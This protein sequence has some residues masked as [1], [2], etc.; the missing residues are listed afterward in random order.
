MPNS[1]RS[2]PKSSA[3][4]GDVR[5]SR[6]TFSLLSESDSEAETP[7]SPP[8]VFQFQPIDPTP[9]GDQLSYEELSI[10]DNYVPI[11]S[12][13][14]TETTEADLWLQ[15]WTN[16]LEVHFSDCYDTSALTEAD[17]GAMMTWLYAQGWDIQIETRDVIQACPD[18]LPPRLWIPDRFSRIG[19]SPV[20]YRDGHCHSHHA[21]VTEQKPKKVKS[22][23]VPRFCRASSGGVPCA[24]A[25]CRYV[26]A[27]TMPRLNQP[28]GFGAGCGASDPTGVKRGQ[29]LYMHPGETWD[30]T[31]VITRLPA[32]SV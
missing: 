30:A 26:H 21:P 20:V 16:D 9:W 28:C 32:S 4:V 22:A 23:C 19:N 27:D 8:T 5:C 10:P 12:N 1:S 31:M 14:Q 15:P 3:H 2:N 17:Y 24:E 11:V 29:C 18:T 25:G 6:N 7:I 13:N